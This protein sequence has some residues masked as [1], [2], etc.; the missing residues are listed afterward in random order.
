MLEDFDGEYG[1]H[2]K[3]A[4]QRYGGDGDADTTILLPFEC[5]YADQFTSIS[6]RVHG[7]VDAAVFAPAR[8]CAQ[9][10]CTSFRSPPRSR[11]V[12]WH[13]FFAHASDECCE[14]YRATVDSI[15]IRINKVL[16]VKANLL[17]EAINV[18]T[19][20]ETPNWIKWVGRL[21]DVSAIERM[22]RYVSTLI[23]VDNLSA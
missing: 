18:F 9:I 3:E 15:D 6:T 2:G 10:L 5:I 1:S 13:S 20:Y 22:E 12:V 17:V 11:Y 8:M 7:D 21:C 4:W 23:C 16:N 19:G 14:I